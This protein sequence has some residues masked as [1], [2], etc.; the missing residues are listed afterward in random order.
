MNKPARLFVTSFLLFIT[1]LCAAQ[2]QK[3]ALVGGLLIDGSGE[4]PLRN[5]IVLVSG[6]RIEA[7]GAIGRLA[8]PDDYQLVSTEGMTVMPGLWDPHVH[9][10]YNGHPDFGH[11]FS[12]YA[13]RFE[14]DTIPASARQFLMAGVTSVRDLAAN[15]DDI[16]AV[17]KRI[18][19]GEIPGPTIYASGMAL[20][21]GPGPQRT[22]HVFPVANAD[23]AIRETRRLADKGMDII[24][25]LGATDASQEIV[26]AIVS[27]AHA[28]GM[29]VTAH[30][31]TD[32]EIRVALR[33]GVDEIQHIGVDSPTY[34]VDILEM[35][36]QR[37]AAGPPLYWNPTVGTI[38]NADELAADPEW[39]DDPKNFAGLPDDIELDIRQ[40]LAT[41]QY[42][43]Q[44][45]AAADTI[46]RKLQSLG[47]RGVIFV[48][49]SDEGTF[50][51]PASEATWRELETWV[52]ELGMDPLVALKWATAD[53][54]AYMGVADEVGTITPGKLADII[55]VRGSPLRH[56]STMREPALVIRHGIRYK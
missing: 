37:V 31:R 47:E 11:W 8:V 55:A 41:A 50:G 20:T 26:N 45:P 46:K 1:G 17:R 49:G 14:S 42:T 33:A 51:H 7:V 43:V 52:F 23:I 30:G 29:K 19:A 13:D 18:E 40:A 5:S 56:F 16:V 44:P 2:P 53:A 22:P 9:L 39:L 6:D 27:T 15:T 54:A 12:T 48:F 3:Y 25:V 28:G 10:L 34:P 32:A 21:P 38:L 36:E 4:E 35:I 24:K